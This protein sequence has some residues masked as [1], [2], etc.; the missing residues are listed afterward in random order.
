M[1]T[2]GILLERIGIAIGIAKQENDDELFS[3]LVDLLRKEIQTM[4]EL[5]MIRHIRSLEQIIENPASD[6]QEQGEALTVVGRL[7]ETDDIEFVNVYASN[8]A[9]AEQRFVEVLAGA[10]GLTVKEVHR[11][12]YDVYRILE[13]HVRSWVKPTKGEEK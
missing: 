6:K 11:R 10:C 9:A 5:E 13:G 12:G 3:G 8:E 4:S 1:D 2:T 7:Y